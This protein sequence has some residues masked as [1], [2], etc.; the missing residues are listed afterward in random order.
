MQ[1]RQGQNNQTSTQGDNLRVQTKHSE[2]NML[3][4]NLKMLTPNPKTKVEANMII[5]GPLGG[6]KAPQPQS[7][8][9]DVDSLFKNDGNLGGSA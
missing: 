1:M 9:Q 2:F 3:R 8:I 4:G 5:N 6:L 7:F